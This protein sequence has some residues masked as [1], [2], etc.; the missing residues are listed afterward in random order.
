MDSSTGGSR[1]GVSLPP[2]EGKGSHGQSGERRRRRDD[3]ANGR[4]TDPGYM[5]TTNS[6]VYIG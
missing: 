6:K 2:R 1:E 4:F 3:N 5:S